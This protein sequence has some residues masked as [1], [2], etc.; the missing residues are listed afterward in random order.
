MDMSGQVLHSWSAEKAGDQGWQHVELCR[1]GDLLAVV[2]DRMLVRMDW[3]SHL[4]W[5]LKMRFHHDIDLA[6]NLDIYSLIREEDLIPYGDSAVPIL[7]DRIGIISPE[8]EIRRKISLFQVMKEEIPSPRWEEIDRWIKDP[9]TQQE[10]VKRKKTEEF[11]FTNLDPVNVLHTNTLEII[12]RDIEGLCEKGDLLI[13]CLKLDLIGIIDS[14]DEKLIWK[15]GPGILNKPHHPTLLENGNILIFDNGADRGYSRVLELDPLK[16]ACVW[17]YQ[18]DPQ[19]AFF[20]LSR[21]SSQRLSNGN[22]L[23]TESDK[24]RVFEVTPSGEVV[25]EFYNPEIKEEDKKRAAI[26]RMMRI[27]F[28]IK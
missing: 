5:T 27:R 12:D 14:D 7:D 23:V 3:N 19:E 16:K 6:E 2:K 26:Y 20:S 21:G 13:C 17:Q 9:Q 15:W 1:N 4:V 18:A 24:G 22:T 28:R 25:W 10:L 11:L 8:G